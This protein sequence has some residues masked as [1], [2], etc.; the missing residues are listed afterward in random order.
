MF[1]LMNIKRASIVD[2]KRIYN[3]NLKL[4]Y[5]SFRCGYLTCNST[6]GGSLEIMATVPLITCLV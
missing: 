5:V 6:N 4:Q 1:F 3:G 2:M